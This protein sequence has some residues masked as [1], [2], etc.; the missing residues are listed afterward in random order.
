MFDLRRKRHSNPATVCTT[1]SLFV[2]FVVPCVT[3]TPVSTFEFDEVIQMIG[4][5]LPDMWFQ[6]F[7]G[8]VILHIGHIPR[9]VI[10]PPFILQNHLAFRAASFDGF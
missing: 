3:R 1:H 10:T 4:D 7:K 8:K 2:L 6:P 5:F 9:P